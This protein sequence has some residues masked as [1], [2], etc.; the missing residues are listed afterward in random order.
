MLT[1]SAFGFGSRSYG[2]S[3]R[4]N[5]YNYYDPYRLIEQ[6]A[7][8]EIGLLNAT[9]PHMTFRKND[10]RLPALDGVRAIAVLAVIANHS[11]LS[12]LG[13]IGVDIFF[14]LSGY[15]ITGILL[16]AK[17]FTPSPRAYLV[18]FYMRRALRIL[19]L[20]WT[21]AVIMVLVR[22]EWSGLLWYMG[23]LVNWLPQAP[24]PT[25]LGHYWSLAVEEQFYLIW[26]ILVLFAS[27]ATLRRCAFAVIGTA[28]ICRFAVSMWPPDSR[29]N[30]L[31]NLP[32]SH[33]PTRWP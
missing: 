17:A 12:S 25:D 32:R 19:P 3:V 16:D 15:L 20:A 27:S 22:G 14:G 21:V 8:F 23:F 33:A 2:A 1:N 9:V 28:I 13:G 24:P 10:A 5:V 26:P 4:Q 31:R 11:G 6:R 18:P 7:P 29:R 30:N